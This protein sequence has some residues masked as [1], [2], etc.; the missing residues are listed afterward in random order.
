[1]ASGIVLY[2]GRDCRRCS[3]QDKG[4]SPTFKGSTPTP[5]DT[6]LPTWWQHTIYQNGF[7]DQKEIITSQQGS[8]RDAPADADTVWLMISK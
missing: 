5:T 1:M 4:S 6:G 7:T 8:P 3:F 2:T